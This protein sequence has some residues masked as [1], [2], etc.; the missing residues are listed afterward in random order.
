MLTGFI[1]AAGMGGEIADM[2]VLEGAASGRSLAA[3]DG[4]V[5]DE[6]RS[7]VTNLDGWSVLVFLLFPIFVPA[8]LL[9]LELDPLSWVSSLGF[10]SGII[11]EAVGEGWLGVT[12][13]G[14][15]GTCALFCACSL[16]VCG[17]GVVGVFCGTIPPFVFL[18]LV[19]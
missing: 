2:L 6:S 1:I 14:V 3:L 8:P 15:S 4:F 10:D 17:R 11:T 19:D 12:C 7:E 9:F 13:F 16:F 5:F 18:G